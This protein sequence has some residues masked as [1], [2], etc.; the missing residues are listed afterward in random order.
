MAFDDKGWPILPVRHGGVVGDAVENKMLGA[1]GG[2]NTIRTRIQTLPNGGKVMLRTRAGFPEFT[3]EEKPLAVAVQKIFLDNGFI[4]PGYSSSSATFA[5]T[6][7]IAI[8]ETTSTTST[9]AEVLASGI[10]VEP[11]SFPASFLSFTATSLN[12]A[13]KAKNAAII[14]CPPTM[15]TG[16]ARRYVSAIYGKK[17]QDAQTYGL[18][19]TPGVC[20]TLTYDGV[21][22]NPG[23]VTT[24]VVYSETLKQYWLVSVGGSNM[25]YARLIVSAA[26]QEILDMVASAKG[27]NMNQA[28]HSYVLSTSRVEKISGAVA[29]RDGGSFAAVIGSP[30]NFGWRFNSDGTKFTAV[31]LDQYG[32][33]VNDSRLYIGGISISGTGELNVSVELVESVIGWQSNRVK[34]FYPLSN[35]DYLWHQTGDVDPSVTNAPL[36]S[37]YDNDDALIVARYAR[38]LGETTAKKTLSLSGLWTHKQRGWLQIPSDLTTAP[39]GPCGDLAFPTY[40]TTCGTGTAGYEYLATGVGDSATVSVGSTTVIE[41]VVTGKENY[42]STISPFTDYYLVE[43]AMAVMDGTPISG[44]PTTVNGSV[45]CET[46]YYPLHGEQVYYAHYLRL[47]SGTAT[48]QRSTLGETVT[49][50]AIFIAPQDCP[51]SWYEGVFESTHISP[52]VD[53]AYDIPPSQSSQKFVGPETLLCGYGVNHDARKEVLSVIVDEQHVGLTHLRCVTSHG[54]KWDVSLQSGALPRASKFFGATVS[55]PVVNAFVTV[56]EDMHGN[57]ACTDIDDETIKYFG[58]PENG[59]RSVGWQ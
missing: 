26:G 48:H 19:H 40:I 14:D 17:L 35:A 2:P 28:F 22:L 13:L 39:S 23:Q 30:L 59:I 6:L 43:T 5:Q 24:G 51:T 15:F 18:V 45:V 27:S 3:M 52:R 41:R 56:R 25:I 36:L 53:K 11:T 42:T 49:A 50:N 44:N 21:T 12:D 58:W 31:A 4:T 33:R 38:T 8:A 20:P 34:I 46:A 57:V 37:F 54:T 7:P 10:K 47:D 29:W 9:Y 1:V 55:S 32:D 16:L